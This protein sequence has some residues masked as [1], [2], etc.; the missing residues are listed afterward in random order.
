M[1]HDWHQ[2]E[3][4][5]AY[6]AAQLPGL[7]G[8]QIQVLIHHAILRRRERS[9]EQKLFLVWPGLRVPQLDFEVRLAMVRR[10]LLLHSL[11][12]DSQLL[13]SF[14]EAEADLV[15]RGITV[16]IGMGGP[17]GIGEDFSLAHG[18]RILQGANA[19]I[20]ALREESTGSRTAVRGSIV[21]YR[22]AYCCSWVNNS[23]VPFTAYMLFTSCPYLYISRSF[24]LSCVR[25]TAPM[26]EQQLRAAL[27]SSS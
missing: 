17:D 19:G 5:V 1:G 22:V 13:V 11:K 25:A 3:A 24:V 12:R 16:Q 26:A 7:V 4:I 9:A 20:N 14:P 27:P 15:K 2:L 23:S 10:L 6:A 8:V 21:Q 18:N